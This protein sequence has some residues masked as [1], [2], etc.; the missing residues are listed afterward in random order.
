MG[1]CSRLALPGRVATKRRRYQQPGPQGLGSVSPLDASID[2]LGQAIS[3]G[4]REVAVR[5]SLDAASFARGAEC[6]L[7]ASGLRMSEETLRQL[8]E[9]EG[10]RVMAAQEAEQLEFDW[11]ACDCHVIGADGKP[12][13][14]LYVG[15]DGVMVPVVTD[16]EKQ[17]RRAKAIE[18]RKKLPR[19]KGVRRGRL[20][21]LKRGADEHFK[22]MKLVT[23]YD[24]QRE[25]RLVRATRKG[26]REAGRLMRQG[27]VGLLARGA[28][29]RI[30][31]VDGAPWIARQIEQRRPP[32]TAVTLDFWHLCQHV[33]EARRT[34]FGETDG[35]GK[36]WADRVLQTIREQGYD[37]F[38][39][40]LTELRGKRR[41]P[42]KRQCMDRLMHYVA[43]RRDMLD[44]PRHAKAGWDIGSGPTESMCKALT[45][46]VKGRG[47]RWDTDNAEAMMA[48]EALLQSH[49]WSQWWTHRLQL[50]A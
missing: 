9:S 11:H 5:L 29:E 40:E 18:R 50:A 3:L 1:S 49:L 7:K 25:H 48:L 21:A 34:L 12:T 8:A 41:S 30:G 33:H 32:F 16:V 15:A 14:R 2:A 13:T 31:L 45:Q 43:A 23:F 35:D 38:W 17:K 10:R 47:K 39:R 19:R 26:P 44:Y 27:L 4:V 20:P 36:A 22:E 28:A 46:R 37:P 24:Q 42:V 6:L